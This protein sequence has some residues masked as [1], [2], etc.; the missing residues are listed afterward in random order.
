M[1]IIS[2][3]NID[4]IEA[5][6]KCSGYICDNPLYADLRRLNQILEFTMNVNGQNSWSN[7]QALDPD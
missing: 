6:A 2:Y 4:I 7:H 5:D 1:E 3:T